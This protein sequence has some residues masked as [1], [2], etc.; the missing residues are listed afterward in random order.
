LLIW[1]G[2]QVRFLGNMYLDIFFTFLWVIG[3]TNAFNLVD[4]MDGLAVGL[5]GITAAFLLIGTLYAGQESLA[6]LSAILLGGCVGIF[7]FNHSPSRLFLGDSGAQLLGFILAALAL[8][9]IPPGLPQ[10]SSWFVPILFFSI[11]ILILLW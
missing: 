1:Q 4:S 5:G 8:V 9:Y 10:L 3:I 7:Y 2:I 11:P 6:F